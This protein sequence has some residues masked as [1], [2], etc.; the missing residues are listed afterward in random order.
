MDYF[1]VHTEEQD[2]LPLPLQTF[3]LVQ[4]WNLTQSLRDRFIYFKELIRS[5]E[6]I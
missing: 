1:T 6:G 3:N 2:C 4:N 5:K